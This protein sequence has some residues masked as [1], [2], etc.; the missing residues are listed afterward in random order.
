[1]GVL[2]LLTVYYERVKMR[3][4]CVGKIAGNAIITHA[5]FGHT[6]AR[7]DNSKY[8]TLIEVVIVPKL[9]QSVIRQAL[10]NFRALTAGTTIDAYRSLRSPCRAVYQQ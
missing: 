1:M 2:R 5:T 8:K 4:Y 7:G 3:T 9:R 10:C 6:V